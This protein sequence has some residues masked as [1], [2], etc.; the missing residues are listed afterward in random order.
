MT[1]L[2]ITFIVGF[3][4]IVALFLYKFRDLQFTGPLLL[5]DSIVLPPETE[6]QAFT[7]GRDWYAIVTQDDRILI[8]GREGDQPVQEIEIKQKAYPF[9]SS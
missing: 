9:D 6:V 1:V 7:Q 3:A 4:I 5:P 2:T 8:Y